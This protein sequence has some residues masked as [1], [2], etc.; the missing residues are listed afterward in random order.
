[1]RSLTVPLSCPDCGGS[2]G[3]EETRQQWECHTPVRCGHTWA[4]NAMS[5]T[6][7]G[8]ALPLPTLQCPD[9]RQNPCPPGATVPSPSSGNPGAEVV[10]NTA[11][12]LWMCRGSVLHH[13]Y[14]TGVPYL[15]E[16]N[17]PYPPPPFYV[18]YGA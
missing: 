9:C 18:K 10:W 11:A 1:M 8:T 6:E 3:W 2:V 5:N 16:E 17:S 13:W 12:R 15:G 4:F 7:G 14:G